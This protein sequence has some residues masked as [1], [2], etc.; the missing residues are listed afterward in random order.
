MP[1]GSQAS[2]IGTPTANLN[3]EKM[4]IN[5]DADKSYEVTDNLDV[6][7]NKKTISSHSTTSL[8]SL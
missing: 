7:V 6:P 1:F 4:Y 5:E 8:M 2:T 3:N